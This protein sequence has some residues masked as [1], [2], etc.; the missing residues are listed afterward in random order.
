[1][2]KIKK[3]FYKMFKDPFTVACDYSHFWSPINQQEILTH[4]NGLFKARRLAKDWCYNHSSGQA[5]ILEGHVN[6]E[7]KN[8]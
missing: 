6:W 5:R 7:D 4:T 1:M 3:W 2:V 8:E